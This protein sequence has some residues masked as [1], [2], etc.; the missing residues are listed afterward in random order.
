MLKIAQKFVL[1]CILTS[2]AMSDTRTIK[3]VCIILKIMND[4]IIEMICKI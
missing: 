4:V 1:H 2:Q 3:K